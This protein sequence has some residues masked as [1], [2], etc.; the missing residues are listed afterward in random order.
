MLQN[1]YENGMPCDIDKIYIETFNVSLQKN[2]QGEYFVIFKIILRISPQK[3]ILW[4]L[5]RSPS[6]LTTFVF[7]ES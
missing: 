1:L 2:G 4:V 6:V 5:I 3:N 7:M